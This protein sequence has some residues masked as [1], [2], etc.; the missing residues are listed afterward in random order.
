M[1]ILKRIT[2]SIHIASDRNTVWNILWNP[3]TY[4]E[5]S[6]MFSEGSHCKG[7]LKQGNTIHFL[8][9]DGAGISSHIE[10]LKENEQLVFANHKELK[11][12]VEIGNSWEGAKEI[13]N[14]KDKGEHATG[15]QVRVDTTPDMEGYF[16]QRFPQALAMVKR[17]SEQ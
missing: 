1:K 15:L 3:E 4:E 10:K 11:N 8:N 13:Y 2:F 16:Q 12:G 7:E 5:W 17:L 9:K 14:L 6:S